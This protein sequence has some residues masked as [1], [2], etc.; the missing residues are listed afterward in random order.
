M[1]EIEST[2]AALVRPG[3]AAKAAAQAATATAP[4]TAPT[5]DST[6]ATA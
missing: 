1:A 4:S 6:P 3:K 2:Y 5:S